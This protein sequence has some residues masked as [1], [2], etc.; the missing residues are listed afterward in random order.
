MVPADP[1]KALLEACA[2][3]EKAEPNY[4]LW[5]S[6]ALRICV[7]ALADVLITMPFIHTTDEPCF[8]PSCSLATRMKEALARAAESLTPDPPGRAQTQGSQV[9]PR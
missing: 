2:Y 1:A 6:R 7:E 3:Y 4:P 8:C 9:K 5:V